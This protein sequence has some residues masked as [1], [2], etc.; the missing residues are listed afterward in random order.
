MSS[1]Q[2]VEGT[3]LHLRVHRKKLVHNN[4]YAEKLTFAYCMQTFSFKKSPQLH[5]G[6]Q[7]F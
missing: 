3:T 6:K 1:F 7:P 2:Q 5:R 4:H